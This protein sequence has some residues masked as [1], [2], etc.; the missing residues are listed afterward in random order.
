MGYTLRC[1]EPVIVEDMA[2]DQRFR[3]SAGARI[4]GW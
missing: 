2:T 4:T 3:A 1:R